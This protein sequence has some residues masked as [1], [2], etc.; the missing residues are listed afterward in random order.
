[1]KQLT[2]LTKTE[3]KRLHRDGALLLIDAG[4]VRLERAVEVVNNAIDAGTLAQGRQTA[5][6]AHGFIDTSG[7]RVYMDEANSIVYLES[8]YTYG[9]RD[10]FNTT[11]Y[12]VEA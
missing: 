2:K 4:P 3:F 11:I 5:T 8:I 6:G 10:A 12:R 9:G 1:M 7:H